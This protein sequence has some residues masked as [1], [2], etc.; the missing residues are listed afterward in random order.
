MFIDIH[1]H[2]GSLAGER[3]LR[4][5]VHSIGIHPWNISLENTENLIVDFDKRVVDNRCIS[6]GECGLDKLCK[7][8]L[9]LQERVFLHQIA[10]SEELGLPVIIHCVKV[11]D[12]LLRIRKELHPRQPWIFHG[13]RGKRELLQQLLSHGFYISFGINHN[14]ESLRSCPLERIFL[15]TD[16]VEQPISILYNKVCEEIQISAL[17]L[18]NSIQ[19]NFMRVFSCNL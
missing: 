7:V 8:P 10:K 5:D 18:E 15:E 11:V 14:V 16:D 12:E 4:Q 1:T 6:V 2:H 19:K 3:V 17:T 9:D 13:F